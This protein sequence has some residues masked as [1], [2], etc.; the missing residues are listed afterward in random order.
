MS[1]LWGPRH[2]MTLIGN[3]AEIALLMTSRF[4]RQYLICVSIAHTDL[5]YNLLRALEWLMRRFDWPR[6]AIDDGTLNS[7]YRYDWWFSNL[8]IDD[9]IS[10]RGYD[11]SETISRAMRRH[12][13]APDDDI[14][15][16]AGATAADAYRYRILKMTREIRDDAKTPVGDGWFSISYADEFAFAAACHVSVSIYLP[17]SRRSCQQLM[18]PARDWRYCRREDEPAGCRMRSRHAAYRRLYASLWSLVF[19]AM[20]MIDG[21]IVSHCHGR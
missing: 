1:L 18:T 20:S 11:G 5:A 8:V 3:F 4:D 15:A 13:D 6:D 7:E 10:Q 12:Y 19:T 9:M 17:H 16:I 21:Q 2:E 14:I